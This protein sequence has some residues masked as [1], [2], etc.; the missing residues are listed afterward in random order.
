MLVMIFFFE[1]YKFN[2]T[3]NTTVC[4]SKSDEKLFYL[5]NAWTHT[6]TYMG[7]SVAST[8]NNKTKQSLKS[9]ISR[10][11]ELATINNWIHRVNSPTIDNGGNEPV[12]HTPYH[13]ITM[14]NFNNCSF[15]FA[16]LI[17]LNVDEVF[18]TNF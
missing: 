6:H 3:G 15:L 17:D 12:S 7:I 10:W 13:H 1:M 18:T 9:I 2:G 8:R 4:N 16:D 11:K 14:I 5:L